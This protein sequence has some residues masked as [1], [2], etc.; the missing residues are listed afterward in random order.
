MIVRPLLQRSAKAKTQ[1][2][3]FPFWVLINE[4][5]SHSVV[6]H[7][8]LLDFQWHLHMHGLNHAAYISM[9]ARQVTD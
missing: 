3:I 2:D 4:V 9:Q 8:R 1:I 7:L 6:V 5:R